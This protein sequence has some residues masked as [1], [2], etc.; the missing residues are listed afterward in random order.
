MVIEKKNVFFGSVFFCVIYTNDKRRSKIRSSG[1]AGVRFIYSLP[2]M[3][4]S[5]ATFVL[6]LVLVLPLIVWT[7][8]KDTPTSK[9]LILFCSFFL[10][11]QILLRLPLYYEVLNLV[12]GQWNW[13]GKILAIAGSVFFYV[14]FRSYFAEHDFITFIQYSDSLR[15]T[16]L[17]TI[18]VAILSVG[19]TLIFS[20]ARTWHVETLLYQLTCPGI[21]EE[22][23]F[24]GIM[25]GLLC[26]MLKE[27]L[28]I[29]RL[30]LGAPALWVTALLFGMVHGLRILE[31]WHLAMDWTY[32]A[33]TFLFSL[34]W[35]WMV[36]YSRSMLMPVLSH[37]LTNFLG[38]LV[39][40]IR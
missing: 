36:L 8:R 11:N 28:Y 15:I 23:A 37:N 31:T 24:R 7:L 16:L 10:L 4:Q 22:L 13:S 5:I 30:F 18:G 26:T 40:M 25:L 6:H 32:F 35:G 34:L 29:G 1:S 21:D 14:L 3:I 33:Q 27:K 2:A 12:G 17:V 9:L 20:D 19:L 39:R 38:T